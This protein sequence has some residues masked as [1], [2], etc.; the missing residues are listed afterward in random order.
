M[1]SRMSS[2]R[3]PE[4]EHRY[5]E[6]YDRT[7][8]QNWPVP[9]R[10]VDIATTWGLT[11][12]RRSGAGTGIPLVMLHPTAGSSAG[13]YPVMAALS[14]QRTVYTP[15][16]IGA[17]GRSDQV[18]PITSGS[19]LVAW[20]DEVLDGLGVDQAHLLGY[21]EGGWIAG[22]YAALTERRDR[23]ASLVLIEPA[24]ALTRVPPRRIAALVLRGMR[25]LIARD[26]PRALRSF[27]RWMNGDVELT[28]QQVE[29]LLAALRGFRQRLPTASVLCDDRLTRITAPTLLLMGADTRLYDPVTVGERAHRL[30]PDVEIEIVPNAGHGVLFQHAEHATARVL[31]FLRRHD[32]G[33]SR[34]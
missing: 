11:R 25:V 23:V 34:A 30:L 1:V 27:N 14:S 5:L 15:D 31:D 13:W 16:T 6:L 26:K 4:A 19:Q 12:V 20:L 33:S 32:H 17:A 10:D 24:G 28:E 2:W 8:D 29:L 18:L 7:I 21:S 9:H 22:L 3:T